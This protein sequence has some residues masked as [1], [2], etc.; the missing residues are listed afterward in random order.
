MAKRARNNALPPEP[1]E[2]IVKIDGYEQTY[3]ISEHGLDG[4]ATS[5]EALIDV[6][7]RIIAISKKL[8]QHL[9]ERLD[10]SFACATSYSENERTPVSDKPFLLP[11]N[12]R[13]DHRSFMTYLPAA[14]FWSIPEMIDAGRLTHIE[15][16]FSPPQ[17]GSGNLVSVYLM[18]ESKCQAL[19][20]E[21]ADLAV[22][23]AI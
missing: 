19:I 16:R 3:Y 9:N 6:Q 2:L 14:A 8:K 20:Q 22:Q 10:V 21:R 13:K 11:M 5:D 7:G 23:S 1:R 18:P 17:Y 12:L 15:A 4:R